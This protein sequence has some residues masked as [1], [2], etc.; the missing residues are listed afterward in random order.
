MRREDLIVY[1]EEVISLDGMVPSAVAAMWKGRIWTRMLASAWLILH[2]NSLR[3]GHWPE[4]RPEEIPSH[5][6][7]YHHGPQEIP[8]IWAAEISAR[9]KECG[10]DGDLLW[11][12]YG[13][14]DDPFVP[15]PEQNRVINRALEYCSGWRR[16]RRCY[17]DWYRRNYKA[18]K[19]AESS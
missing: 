12:Y 7:A 6:G 15:A 5:G 4:V 9:I 8:A 19:V 2:Y 10:R 14:N 13:D 1:R 18:H 3:D 17:R 16:K 11:R